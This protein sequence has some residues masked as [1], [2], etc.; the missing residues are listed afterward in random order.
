MTETGRNG[1]VRTW[2]AALAD[3]SRR[4]AAF[5]ALVALA[6]S[7]FTMP[8]DLALTLFG[9]SLPMF[10]LFIWPLVVAALGFAA[11]AG[12]RAPDA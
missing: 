10:G 9:V 7:A 11:L 6:A 8:A 2:V 5:T 3:P 12:S 4:D 1:G